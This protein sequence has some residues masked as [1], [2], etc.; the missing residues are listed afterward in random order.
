MISWAIKQ[1]LLENV[2][3]M[4]KTKKS[5]KHLILAYLKYRGL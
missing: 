5:L 4:L 3:I 2:K 1:R